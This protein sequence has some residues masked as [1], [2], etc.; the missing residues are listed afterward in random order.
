M[1]ESKA[2]GG[3]TALVT[4]GAGFSYIDDV[5]A[6]IVDCLDLP[7]TIGETFNVGAD[8]PMSVNM[9]AEAVM[10]AMGSRVETTHLPAR[11]EVVHAYSGHEK[12]A[13]FFPDLG[14]PHPLESG[15]LRM[16]LWARAHGPRKT[17]VFPEVELL[18]NM[19]PSWHR[20]LDLA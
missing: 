2:N 8:T 18:Q 19:P 20:E 14:T 7:D 10:E 11:N 16:A 1:E 6:P 5:A 9:L 15:L 4:G 13:H 17:R 3:A 12:I